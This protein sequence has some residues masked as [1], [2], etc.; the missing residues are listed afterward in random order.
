MVAAGRVLIVEDEYIVQLHLR[1]LLQD[2]GFEVTGVAATGD[3]ALASAREREPEL[4]LMD[5]RLANGS[6]GIETARQLRARHDLD[7]VF[8]TA[9]ADERTVG[10]AQAVGPVGYLVKPFSKPQ[11]RATLST[12]LQRKAARALEPASASGTRPARER[13][14]FGAGTRMAI[15]SHDTLGL[16]HLQRNLNLAW[17]LTSRHPELS[18][19]LL[20]GSPA[21]HRYPLPPGVDTIKLPSVRK[22][23]AER[24]ESRS[25]RL[26]DED[27][28]E[29]RRNLTLRAIQGFDPHVLLVDH[30]PAGMGGELLPAL[31]WLA[32]ERP[33]CIRIVGL[34]D[35]VDSP[36]R[37]H[38]TWSRQGIYTLLEERYE[39][40]LIYGMPAV[41]D[42]AQAC[43][44]SERLRAKTSYCGYVARF[45]PAGEEQDLEL[46][47]PSDKPLVVVTIGGGDGAGEEVLGAWLRML[48]SQRTVG[49]DS[50]LLTG[51]F[52]DPELASRLRA[53]REG[54]PARL[55][56]F[57]PSTRPY[58][59][60]A[61]L[62]V[63]TGGYNTMIET[64]SYASKA[65]VI[66]RRMHRDEQLI[67]AHR[68]QELGLV[69]ALE[70]AEATPERLHAEIARLL[71]DPRRPLTEARTHG[72][73]ALDGAQRFVDFVSRL[74]VAV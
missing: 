27:V 56:D 14:P 61:D 37:V 32:R 8:L 68:F 52:V 69:T 20:T 40:V 34:R 28:L 50:V 26:G 63:C 43:G 22:V 41:F 35:V 11:L 19:L 21:L 17:A 54:L 44:F 1:V 29:F 51:P 57:V 33:A 6:D 74:E 70:P 7:V 16:G 67:R 62:V 38:E 53:Q 39:H 24:Y 30:A 66:P 13:R 23:G 10:R 15:F 64:V 48:R 73:I 72:R 46:A 55:V 60:R 25:L 65:L 4:V 49:F 18:I 42:T 71:A 31:D 2:L 36:E 12:A 47:L 5:V 45:R 9:H 59:E 58:L 3:E